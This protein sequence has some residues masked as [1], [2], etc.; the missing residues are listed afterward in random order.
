MKPF[1]LALTYIQQGGFVRAGAAA[2]AAVL[3][4]LPSLIIF[5]LTQSNVVETMKSA[6]IKE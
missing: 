4:M 2:A 1:S 3:M 6:G 5:I